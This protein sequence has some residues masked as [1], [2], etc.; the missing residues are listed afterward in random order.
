[1]IDEIIR[2]L[3]P[4]IPESLKERRKKKVVFRLLFIRTKVWI[5][6]LP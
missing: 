3:S 2:L 1:M 5:V 4:S 6:C